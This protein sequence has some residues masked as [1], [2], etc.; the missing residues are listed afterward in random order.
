MNIQHVRTASPIALLAAALLALSSCATPADPANT[1]ATPDAQFQPLGFVM[2]VD[3]TLSVIDMLSLKEINKLKVGHHAVHQVAVLPDNRTVYTGNIDDGTIVK[4]KFSEDGKTYTSK[5]VAKSPVNLHFFAA[6]PDGKHVVLT[7]RMELQE[8]ST[9][10]KLSA[11]PDDS[12]AIID[13]AT[14]KIVK[15]LALQSPAMPAFPNSGKHV[16]INNAHHGTISVIETA[17]WTEIQRVS[18]LKEALAKR[19]DGTSRVSPDG[20]DVSPD[21][22]WVVSADYEAHSI[23]V[24]EVGADGKL[25][26]SSKVAYENADGMPHDVRFTPDSKEMWVTDYDRVP[27]PADEVGNASMKTHVRVY[28]VATLKSLKTFEYPRAVQR[29]ALPQ[30]SKQAFLTTAMGG[31]LAIDRTTG[32]L[33]GE[34]VSGGLGN[35]VVCGMPATNS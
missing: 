11:L 20:L 30:Y 32:E 31:V 18:V 24:F 6:T 14:D 9:L 4:L 29:I 35:P 12:I 34:M 7:S 23:T 33:Q 15:V 17:T 13:T 10:P 28:D 2:L 8:V 16:Y 27:N 26:K 25:G 22:K 1:E 19:P 5:V 21:G 3:G